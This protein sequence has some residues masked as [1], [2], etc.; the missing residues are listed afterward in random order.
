MKKL[1]EIVGF[2][3]G[4]QNLSLDESKKQLS[5]DLTDIISKIKNYGGN[6]LELEKLGNQLVNDIIKFDEKFT[7]YKDDVF[8]DIT[9]QEKDYFQKSYSL[10]KDTQNDS[11][12]WILN[13][14]N[15]LTEDNTEDYTTR[16][17]LHSSWKFPG[18]Y[19]RP[20]A[21]KI[22]SEMT[23]CDP[24]YIADHTVG[25]LESV[26]DLWTPQYQSRLRYNTI[27]DQDDN[28]FKNFPEN[29]LGLIVATEFF[30][31][32]PLEIIQKYIEQFDTILRPGGVVMFTYNN[33]DLPGPVR[34]V[35]NAFNTYTPGRLLQR[36]I[37][38]KGYEILYANESPN[39]FNWIE[40]KKPGK[41]DSLK[42]GQALAQIKDSR[43]D[44]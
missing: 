26:K 41:F 10:Y 27:N 34:N 38:G 40:Y 19:I 7:T 44:N 3:K 4:I 24:L 25:L 12:E 32:K 9:E 6:Y 28:I 42:G 8:Y 15:P 30:N 20:K 17:A 37:E 13:R 39:G 31:F 2:A 1:S 23:A 5:A 36:I 16:I 29:Q 43:L 18:L 33:C 35:E 14:K 22:I 11:D 21:D